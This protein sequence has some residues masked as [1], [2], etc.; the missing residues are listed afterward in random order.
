M[1]SQR[2]RVITGTKTNLANFVSLVKEMKCEIKTTTTTKE[3]NRKTHRSQSI[4]FHPFFVLELT[5]NKTELY[6]SLVCKWIK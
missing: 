2:D 1:F 4:N 3:R 5:L 6:Q